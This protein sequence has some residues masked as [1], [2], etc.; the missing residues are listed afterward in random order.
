MIKFSPE[1]AAAFISGSN[2]PDHVVT[3]FQTVSNNKFGH[4]LDFRKR[5]HIHVS[6]QVSENL[7]KL[8]TV[9]AFYHFG[10]APTCVSSG[11]RQALLNFPQR[12]QFRFSEKGT[13]T[14][15][16]RSQTNFL[17]FPQRVHFRFLEKG[18][19]SCVSLGCRHLCKI[20]HKECIL[21]FRKRVHIHVNIFL[22]FSFQHD[23]A[24]D[25]FLQVSYS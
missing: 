5:V 23:L 11:F 19:P 13:H 14:C 22:V 20:F 12:V 18:V 2:V 6:P 15:L 17:N 9:S 16:L 21:D 24:S 4:I 7:F 25:I 8:S 10:N 1:E 3:R